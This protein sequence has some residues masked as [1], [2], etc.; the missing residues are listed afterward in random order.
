MGAFFTNLHVHNASTESVS[1]ALAELIETR[2]YV[3][4]PQNDWVT[5]Y[6]EVTESQ[7]DEI[8]R[9]I[10][11]GLSERLNTDVIAFLVHDS[12]VA[13]YWLFRNGALVDEFNSDPLY[14]GGDVSDAALDRVRGDTDALLPLCAE[15]T[16]R[17]QLDEILHPP[18][19]PPIMAEDIVMELAKLLGIDEMRATL[20]FNYF[21]E[22]ASDSLP[23]ADAF[24][25]VGE[26]AERMESEL[27]DNVTTVDFRGGTNVPAN[28]PQP[29]ATLVDSY[30]IAINMLTQSWNP[31]YDLNTTQMAE[32]FGS[33]AG[34]VMR[35]MQATFDH[36]VRDLLKKSAV[37]S[38]PSWEELIA[39]RD[40]GPESLADVIAKKTPDQMTQ[41]G[42]FAALAGI[43]PFVAALL[44]R[45]LDPQ[46]EGAQDLTTLAAAEQH[47][48]DSSIYRLVK[49]A[50]D[51]G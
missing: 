35:Q 9:E 21:T 10:A 2:A 42:V 13:L 50:V 26:G 12:D 16:M 45:G 33:K 48:Q 22:E 6:S 36:G 30:P 5:I 40:A 51:V 8:L 3:S 37:P 15:G 20:G 25:P 31:K 18:D 46:A 44:R 43:E 28:E 39:A 32:L 34:P 24:E 38:L 23:D 4:P 1:A 27:P 7:D 49:G 11:G 19:G 17:E 14:F 47:G 41:V 29:A